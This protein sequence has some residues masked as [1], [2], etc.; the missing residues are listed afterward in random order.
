MNH[1]DIALN[2]IVLFFGKIALLIIYLKVLDE[3]GVK[4]GVAVYARLAL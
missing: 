2:L 1:S 3:N 4:F